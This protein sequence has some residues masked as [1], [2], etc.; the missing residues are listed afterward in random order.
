MLRGPENVVVELR[1]EQLLDNIQ[2]SAVAYSHISDG[3]IVPTYWS[4]MIP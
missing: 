4:A 1:T 3:E 2:S